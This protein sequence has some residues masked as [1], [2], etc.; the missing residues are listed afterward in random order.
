MKINADIKYNKT[1]KKKELIPRFCESQ[2]ST[3]EWNCQTEKENFKISNGSRITKQRHR[4][5]K[6]KKEL[7]SISISLRTTKD[8][9]LFNA[10]IKKRNVDVKKQNQSNYTST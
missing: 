4:T 9:I 7:R 6:T 2:L 8:V 3:K 5:Q 1:Y 10:I